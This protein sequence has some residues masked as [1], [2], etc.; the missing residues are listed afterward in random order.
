MCRRIPGC[1]AFVVFESY[2][3]SKRYYCLKAA[4][5]PLALRPELWT[6]EYCQGSYVLEGE[7][8]ARPFI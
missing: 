2:L 6:L 4:A 7:P 8:S 1:K 3:I 5:G